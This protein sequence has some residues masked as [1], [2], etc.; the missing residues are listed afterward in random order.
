MNLKK[1]STEELKQY[2]GQDGKPVCIAFDGKVY[3]VTDSSFWQGG[4]HFGAHQA[5]MDL[6]EAMKTAPHS[7]EV[8]S[9][10]KQIGIL[11]H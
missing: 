3:D 7:D 2:N 8:L 4:D 9:K 6:T 1:V 11:A 10:V 5:G